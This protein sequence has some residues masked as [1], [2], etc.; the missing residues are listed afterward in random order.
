MIKMK[1]ERVQESHYSYEIKEIKGEDL[2]KDLRDRLIA[3]GDLIYKLKHSHD[4]IIK[5]TIFSSVP[6]ACKN[7]YCIRYRKECEYMVGEY[8]SRHDFISYAYENLLFWLNAVNIVIEEMDIE[9][10]AGEII[11]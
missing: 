3:N 11:I 9:P 6:Q 4:K 5:I 10:W 1:L 7:G 8:L 2:S